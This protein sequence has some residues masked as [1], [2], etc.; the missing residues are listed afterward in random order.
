MADQEG[1]ILIDVNPREIPIGFQCD[2][3]TGIR[4]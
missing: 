1:V 3:L 4:N 2:H